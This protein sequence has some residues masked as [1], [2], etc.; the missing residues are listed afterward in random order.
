MKRVT[1]PFKILR[2][3]ILGAVPQAES[4]FSEN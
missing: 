4:V 2:I 3:F 1:I